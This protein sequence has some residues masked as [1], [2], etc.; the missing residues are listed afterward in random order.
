MSVSNNYMNVSPVWTLADVDLTKFSGSKVRIAFF[1][2]ENPASGVT[3]GWHIDNIQIIATETLTPR[4]LTIFPRSGVIPSNL[5]FDFSLIM[6]VPGRF[7]VGKR[8][9]FDG[10]DVTSFLERCFVQGNLPS[11]GEAFRCPGLTGRILGIGTHTFEVTL[12]LN[13]GTSLSDSAIWRVVEN[14]E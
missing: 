3:S 6:E 5:H 7:V 12:D 4:S 14:R 1:H 10:I 13:D 8:A 9:T 11:G 2:F